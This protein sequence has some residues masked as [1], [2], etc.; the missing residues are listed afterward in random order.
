[1]VAGVS[2]I[3]LAVLVIA[4]DDG[5]MPQTIEHVQIM[6]LLGVR[7]GIVALTK[8]DLVDRDAVEARI[9]EIRDFLSGTFLAGAP[10]APVSSETFEGI[11][12]FFRLLMAEIARARTQPRLAVFRMPIERVFSRPGHGAVV[13]GI[14]VEGEIAVGD[15]VE[16]VPGGETGKLRGIQRFLRP[17]QRGGRGQCLALNIPDFSKAAPQRGQVV[18]QAGYLRPASIFHLALRVVPG[19][20]RPLR[21][22]EEIKFHVGTAEASGKLYLL[23]DGPWEA[24]ARG[25]ATVAL[26]E[27]LA[28]AAHDRFILRRPSPPAT[29]AG[30]EILAAE[31]GERRPPRKALIERLRAYQERLAGHDPFSPEGVRAR[32]EHAL[33]RAGP[34]GATRA[35]ISRTALLR[36]EAV[37]EA[38]KALAA[39]GAAAPLDS[40]RWI[41]AQACRAAVEE[42]R[43]IVKEAWAGKQAFSV[44]LAQLKKERDWPAALWRAIEENLERSSL[45][46]RRGGK[47]ID[48][49]AA[50][51]L[52]PQDRDL[53]ERIGA[54][55]RETGFLSPRPD[56]LPARLGAAERDIERILEHLCNEK[57]LIR[58]AKTVILDYGHFLDAQRKVVEAIKAKGSLNS[59]DFKYHIDSSRKYALAILDYLDVLRVT[60]REDAER[61]LAPNYEQR[62]LK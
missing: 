24:N 48:P 55:Y 61:R 26:A 7:R 54:V 27:P 49:A 35:E 41:H 59:A 60:I 52:S 37:E 62:M 44:P 43:A 39:S 11:D 46:A 34:K 21:N 6:E 30:G 50:D 10:V 57:R 12:D 29:V 18:C 20:D 40:E 45:A 9:V 15:M 22:A 5:V 53:A 23:D 1:M 13:T 19:V 28:A 51:A 31:P 25:L 58:L 17:A 16:L 42:I 32:V 3:E 47:L 33:D 8:I 56:E 2:G 38:L 14:P 36:G 4:A